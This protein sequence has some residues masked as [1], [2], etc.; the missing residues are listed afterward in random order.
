MVNLKKARFT[1]PG[2]TKAMRLVSARPSNEEIAT[3][4]AGSQWG[5]F[6]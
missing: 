5:V 4:S 2:S 6:V 3:K 1:L